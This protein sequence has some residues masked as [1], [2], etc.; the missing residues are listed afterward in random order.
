MVLSS[1]IVFM[2]IGILVHKD[3]PYIAQTEIFLTK[4]SHKINDFVLSDSYGFKYSD[5]KVTKNEFSSL[6]RS[7]EIINRILK[8]VITVSGKKDTV[9]NHTIKHE[10][11][12]IE[13]GSLSRLSK[14]NIALKY[15][16]ENIRTIIDNKSTITLEVLSHNEELGIKTSKLLVDKT[17]NLIK[18]IGLKTEIKFRK[19]LSEKI[20]SLVNKEPLLD[21]ILIRQLNLQFEISELKIAR[22]ESNLEVISLPDYPLNTKGFSLFVHTILY[23]IIGIVFSSLFV[24]INS[25]LNNSL[26]EKKTDYSKESK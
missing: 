19:K 13:G 9:F 3:G 11:F 22:F 12:N 20:D 7:S 1:S 24:L 14:R 10:G 18:S 16:R 21:S 2:G 6:V 5:S 15:L 8:E 25:W 17:K 26:I 23:G 4:D